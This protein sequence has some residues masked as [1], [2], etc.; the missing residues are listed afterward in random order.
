MAFGS[1]SATALNIA[2]N[3]GRIWLAAV[4]ERLERGIDFARIGAGRPRAGLAEA[5]AALQHQGCVLRS[6]CRMLTG[7]LPAP[8]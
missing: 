7:T 8:L 6:Q 4:T 2:S 1:T 5:A 3:A